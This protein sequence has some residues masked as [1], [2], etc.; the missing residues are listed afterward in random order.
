[1]TLN[2]YFLHSHPLV[3]KRNKGSNEPMCT[4]QPI[5]I[6]GKN[7]L[8]QSPKENIM[9]KVRYL[10]PWSS[11][12]GVFI[13]KKFLCTY[14]FRFYRIYYY[15]SEKRYIFITIDCATSF[16]ISTASPITHSD[17]VSIFNKGFKISR[18]KQMK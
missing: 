3:R 18:N 17:G 16:P 13:F 4:K 5:F 14:M 6:L 2:F 11:V 1:M 8:I 7:H 10:S 12:E 15:Q 9:N